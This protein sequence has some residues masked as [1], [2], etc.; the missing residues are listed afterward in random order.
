M[1]KHYTP[2]E[3]DRETVRKLLNYGLTHKETASLI[4]NP[5]TGKPIDPATLRRH[6]P[7]ECA[8]SKTAMKARLIESLYERALDKFNP[9]GVQAAMFIL[10]CQH[11]WRETSH[12]TLDVNAN[13][14]VLIAPAGTTPEEWLKRQTQRDAPE[15]EF[16]DGDIEAPGS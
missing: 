14:G 10:K 3:K 13:A 7:Q 15:G 16:E 4:E 1:P 12:H 9:R 5:H 6:F 11:G 8:T 2:T